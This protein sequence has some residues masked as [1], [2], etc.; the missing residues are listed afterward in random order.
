M[1]VIRSI[2]FTAVASAVCSAQAPAPKLEFEVASIKPS[3]PFTG[4][5][6]LNV[7]VHIDGSQVRC[8]SLALKDYIRMAYKVKD[9]QI[10]GPE[11]MGSERYD[12]NA[13]VP[14][15]TDRDQVAEMV[16]ALLVDRFQMK[17][18]N[19]KKEFPVYALT[20]AKGGVKMKEVALDPEQ[21]GKPP[22][23]V[24]INAGAA[25]TTVNLGRGASFT[26]AN[27]KIEGYRLTMVQAA[28]LLARFVDRPV[29]DMTENKGTYDFVLEFTP[30]DFRAMMIRSA[31]AAGVALPAEARAYMEAQSGDSLFTALQAIGLKLERQKA[32]LDV[33]VI[34]HVLKTPSEN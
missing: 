17:T 34:D 28:D 14:E 27:N 20:V 10:S 2:V 16:K 32:P 15:G 18:H 26:F 30:E 22:V 31:I 4:G 13:K 12:I 3:A 19:E 7:G 24:K 1:S 25:G 9:Y 33:L 23:D 21:A 29:V 11:W 8:A 6:Q 5:G